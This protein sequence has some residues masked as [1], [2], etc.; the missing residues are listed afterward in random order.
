MKTPRGSLQAAKAIHWMWG[1]KRVTQSVTVSWYERAPAYH[2]QQRS[3]GISHSMSQRVQKGLGVGALME[4]CSHER[5]HQQKHTD[6]ESW[7]PRTGLKANT[8]RSGSW[9]TASTHGGQ[10][11]ATDHILPDSSRMSALAH[12]NLLFMEEK[13]KGEQ[14]HYNDWF[15]NLKLTKFKSWFDWHGLVT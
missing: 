13:S 12:Q 10:R 11:R 5:E 9:A 14:K 8:Q 2:L 15:L 4:S 3:S 6:P 7:G 1:R